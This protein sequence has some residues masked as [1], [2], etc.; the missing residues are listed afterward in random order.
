MN[1]QVKAVNWHLTER[2]NYSC[3]F[4]FMQTIPG[5]EADLARGYEIIVGL[6]KA[7]MTKLNFVG[8]EPLLHPYLK[9]FA[10][11]AKENNFTV[12][13]VTNGYLLSRGLLDQ[14]KPHMDWIG[15]SIDSARDDVESMLGRGNGNHVRKAINVCRAIREIGIKLK[16]N[17]VVTKLNFKE[18][19]RPLIL[20][21]HPLRW[22]VFQMLGILGQ[23]QRHYAELATTRE[24]FEIFK[25]LNREIVLD[26]GNGPVF[27]AEED[28]VDSYLMLAPDGRVIQN[29]LR[30]YVYHNL[31][32]AIASRFEGIVDRRAFVTRGGNYEW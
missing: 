13:M 22:K 31:E 18:D 19:L 14:L 9:E 4:C 11:C 25:D 21:L 28:M 16:V 23:N 27:E 17:T 5:D 29:T 10:S 6:K 26:S 7:G 30:T 32:S 8:G 24:E 2:C 12:S 3:K 15:I 20:E 1:H